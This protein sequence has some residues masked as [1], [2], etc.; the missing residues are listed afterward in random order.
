M[1]AYNMSLWHLLLWIF[2]SSR[3]CGQ[4]LSELFQ[5]RRM[6]C[7]ESVITLVLYVK[8]QCISIY[9]LVSL[10]SILKYPII[11]INLHLY[12]KS[13]CLHVFY[14]YIVCPTY[15]LICVI[16]LGVFDLARI[17][18]C[19]LSSVASSRMRCNSAWQNPQNP[20]NLS[21][22]F[23]KTKH[24]FS[25]FKL[26]AWC[27]VALRASHFAVFSWQIAIDN[28]DRWRKYDI[29]IYSAMCDIRIY[30]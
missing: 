15:C 29:H 12:C 20:K 3:L 24:E 27:S 28:V 16:C 11:Y 1:C 8:F 17:T 9:P 23:P 19:A 25:R 10:R 30:V 6:F 2:L 18:E 7:L 26:R 13:T 21:F 5:L 4:G 22:D 14:I